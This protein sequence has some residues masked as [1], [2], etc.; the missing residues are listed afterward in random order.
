VV[1]EADGAVRP[2]FFHRP[3]GNVRA[4]PL[5]QLVATNLPAFRRTLQVSTNA[6]C[7]RCVCS[8]RTGWGGGPW[9]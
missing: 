7:R 4:T 9:Q 3:I 2:C 8:M 1:V 6:L 5:P